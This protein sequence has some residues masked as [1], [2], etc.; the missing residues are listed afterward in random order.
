MRST[1]ASICLIACV[2]LHVAIH[3]EPVTGMLLLVSGLV[4]LERVV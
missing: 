4:A 2:A 3:Y 1:I